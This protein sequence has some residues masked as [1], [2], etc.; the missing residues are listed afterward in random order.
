MSVFTSLVLSRRKAMEVILKHVAN[1]DDKALAELASRVLEDT[2]LYNCY[3]VVGDG[4]PNDD[5]RLG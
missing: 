3:R 4:E 5:E 1:A 2:T